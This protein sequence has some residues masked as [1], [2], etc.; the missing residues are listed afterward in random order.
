MPDTLYAYAAKISTKQA[1]RS[2]DKD[3]W[4]QAIKKE[5][6]QLFL[7]TLVT[8]LPQGKYGIDYVMI[9]STMQLKL[10]LNDDGS[11][12]K[13]KATVDVVHETT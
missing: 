11:V 9:H 13:Y 8:E 4:Q 3:Q 5:M 1:L 7:N 10:K 6:D 2:L 12:D